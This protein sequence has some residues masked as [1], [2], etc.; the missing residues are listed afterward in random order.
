MTSSNLDKIHFSCR[1]IEYIRSLVDD[2]VSVDIGVAYVKRSGVELLKELLDKI[3]S[4]RVV[5]SLS[6]NLTEPEALEALLNRR[7]RVKIYKEKNDFHPKVYIFKLRDGRAI[8]CVGS[9]NLSKGGLR[10]NVEAN[11]CFMGKPNVS[12]IKEVLEFFEDIL[13]NSLASV[14]LTKELLE[15][16]KRARYI[17]PKLATPKSLQV[18]IES[19]L[20]NNVKCFISGER[21]YWLLITDRDNFEKC[22]EYGL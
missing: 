17:P 11:I 16:Y 20:R 5:T 13:W 7:I 14:D 8:V 22:L 15:E 10:D 19:I 3:E 2:V 1:L 21:R 9:S 6:F 12:P 18:R 4:C